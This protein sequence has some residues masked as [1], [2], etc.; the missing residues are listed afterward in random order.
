MSIQEKE[1]AAALCPESM[2]RKDQKGLIDCMVDVTAM[3]GAYHKSDNVAENKLSQMDRVIEAL[4]LIM[5]SGMGHKCDLPEAQW[6]SERKAWL[7]IV[8]K[9]SELMSLI[10]SIREAEG[11]LFS[12]Q[13]TWIY[14]YL[15]QHHYPHKEIKEFQG[16]SL[17][18][19]VVADTYANYTTLLQTLAHQ[20]TVHGFSGLAEKMVEYHAHKLL[21]IRLFSPDYL[22]FIL[23]TYIHLQDAATPK[24]D[25]ISMY[26]PLFQE[27]LDAKAATAPTDKISATNTSSRCSHCYSRDAH[28]KLSVGVGAKKCP[29]KSASLDR[30]A[31][32]KLAKDLLVAIKADATIDR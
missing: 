31:A 4:P 26:C 30:T 14:S 10:E 20:T 16:S 7:Q 28:L 6:K 23:R 2:H 18:I 29:F 22:T 9:G 19:R 8:K 21:Q 1:V 5:A 12:Q 27:V 15:Y 11:E 17:L 24:F 32:R 13:E 25:D 3:P